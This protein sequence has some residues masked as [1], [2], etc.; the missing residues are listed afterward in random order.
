M[1]ISQ[2]KRKLIHRDGTKSCRDD[3]LIQFDVQFATLE[4]NDAEAESQLAKQMMSG[5]P[6][7]DS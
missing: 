4:L 3:D 6:Y 7:L 1:I 5:R 2:I